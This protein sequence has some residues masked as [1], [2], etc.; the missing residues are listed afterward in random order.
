MWH[1][2]CR[3]AM[4]MPIHMT[5]KLTTSVDKTLHPVLFRTSV[6]LIAT[7]LAQRRASVC[8]AASESNKD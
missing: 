4:L 6:T 2:A 7:S 3:L 8:S 1:A 5:S